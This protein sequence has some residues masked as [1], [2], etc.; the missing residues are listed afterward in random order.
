MKGIK[1]R[2][3]CLS[4]NILAVRNYNA[5]EEDPLCLRPYP[6]FAKNHTSYNISNGD[7]VRVNYNEWATVKISPYDGRKWEFNPEWEDFYS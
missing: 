3:F 7:C 6:S 5:L 1:A 2:N 4:E